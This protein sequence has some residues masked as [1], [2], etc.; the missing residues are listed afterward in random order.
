[1]RT[2]HLHTLSNAELVRFTKAKKVASTLELELSSRLEDLI[3][4]TSESDEECQ[5][6]EEQKETPP[7]RFV[8]QVVIPEGVPYLI[9]EDHPLV[10]EFFAQP[11]R[12]SY[13]LLF[14]RWLNPD[15]APQGFLEALDNM[16]SQTYVVL[17]S[18]DTYYLKNCCA[19]IKKYL[20]H[21]K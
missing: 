1:M 15:Y 21:T 3:E 6:D 13:E 11:E 5:V 14:D 19:T 20:E 10:C 7:P 12:G 8:E 18:S 16:L 9:T 17:I 2:V 4:N